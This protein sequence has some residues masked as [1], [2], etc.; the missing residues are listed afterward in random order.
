M[1]FNFTLKAIKIKSNWF[2]KEGRKKNVYEKITYKGLNLYFQLYKFRLHNQENEHTF[3]TSISMLRKETGYST[4]EV[5]DLLKKMQGAKIIKLN[6]VSRWDY[7]I[8]ENGS[9]RDKDILIITATD[10][11]SS[12]GKKDDDFYIYV[13]LELFEKYKQAGLTEKYFALYC[14][15]AKWSNNMEGKMYMK[16]AKMADHLGFDKD[17]IH[18]MIYKMNR[19]YFMSSHRRTRKGE[20]GYFFEH[21]LLTS[22]KEEEIK[23]FLL[24]EKENM[25][26]LIKRV[27]KKK[28]QKKAIDIENEMPIE[29]VKEE[30]KQEPKQHDV[31]WAFGNRKESWGEPNP[32]DHV[33]NPLG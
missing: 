31:K 18:K 11:I 9:I 16:I 8:D 5:F 33:P 10:A 24:T 7:L 3:I 30:S 23:K 20:H 14:L 17:Y 27:N 4:D 2:D 25:D 22:V 29:E 6:N 26:R 21:H 19:N 1:N 13:P 28:K 12:F 15:I 32:F